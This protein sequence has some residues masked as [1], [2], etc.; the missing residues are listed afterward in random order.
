MN[1]I[2]IS[3]QFPKTY[4]NFCDRLRRNGVTVLGIGDTPYDELDE[5]V[6]RSLTEY[7]KVGN[8]EDYGEM[9]RAVAFFSFKYGKIDWLE[10]NNEYWLTQD[11]RL[12]T[13]FNIT[14]GVKS[15]AIGSF[16]SKE[17][18]KTFY[19]KAGVPTARFHLAAYDGSDKAFTDLVG[20]PVIAKPNVGVGAN[21]TYKLNSDEDLENFQRSH[22]PVPYIMEEFITGDIYSY[23]AITDKSAGII[24]E[25]MTVWP[26]SIADIVNKG[27]DLTYYTVGGPVPEKFSAVGRNTVRAFDVRNRFVHMEFFRLTKAKPGLGEVGDYVGL[28]VNM[29]PAGGYTPDMF[30]FAGSIDVYQIWADM[31][32]FGES[33]QNMNL[34]KYYCV[35]ASQRDGR[36]H[37]HSHDEILAKYGGSM[38]MCDRIPEVLTAAMGNQMYTVKLKTKD[39]VDE[40][41]DFVTAP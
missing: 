19:E 17:A 20:Y 28:E 40:F 22:P 5:E 14:T 35:Y 34:Q 6:K 12:R 39:E 26:P 24:F 10:S 7:Y 29:R 13:D 30:N 1:F 41:I 32:A 36:S 23:D 15:D 18:M 21:D 33:R 11:A 8:M 37:A 25:T 16:K 9:F 38:V 27:L 4:W 31:V 2:F 3:P